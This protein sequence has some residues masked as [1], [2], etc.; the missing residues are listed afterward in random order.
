[1]CPY[2]K[3]LERLDEVL[4]FKQRDQ[5]LKDLSYKLSHNICPIILQL[6]G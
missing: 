6:F 4:I 1:M 5:I 3:Y 2:E